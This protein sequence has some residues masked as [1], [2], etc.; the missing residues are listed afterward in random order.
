M[1]HPL[2]DGR[3]PRYFLA[4]LCA[5]FAILLA[6]AASAQTAS[7]R[8]VSQPIP[9]RYIVVFNDA[10][11]DA[12]GESDRMVRAAG[13]QRHHTFTHAL[14]GFAATLSAD[15]VR[16]LRADPQVAFIEQDHTVGITDVEDLSVTGSWG[17]DRIDETAI[18]LDHQYHYNFTGSGLWAFII[19]TGIRADHTEFTGRVV[20]GFTAIDDGN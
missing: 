19:D 2:S 13:G 15:A 8:Y 9:N 1:A 12:A 7:H 14:K 5:A 16:V 18:A 3:M 6:G 4:R 17:L 10:V 11:A 20:A